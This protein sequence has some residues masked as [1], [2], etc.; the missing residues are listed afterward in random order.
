MENA[1]HVA[2]PVHV[3]AVQLVEF[4][5]NQR[6]MAVDAF[7]ADGGR[8]PLSKEMLARYTPVP[9]DYLVTQEDGYQYINPRE[10]FERKYQAIGQRVTFMQD[11]E[12]ADFL[13]NAAEN[14]IGLAEHSDMAVVVCG[15][16][17]GNIRV[18]STN[19]GIDTIG[20]LRLGEQ[21]IV[22]T[23]IPH[24]NHSN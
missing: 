2:N 24:G 6:T 12:T 17:G 14:V 18:F 16:Y 3:R 15:N 23:I 5:E 21:I 20:V 7:D 10:V 13:R 4:E 11:Q 19:G 9:G 22:N 1:T 8:Y